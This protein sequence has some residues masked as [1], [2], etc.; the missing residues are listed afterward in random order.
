M[1]NYLLQAVADQTTLPGAQQGEHFFV[2][3]NIEGQLFRQSFIFLVQ[4]RLINGLKTKHFGCWI[5]TMMAGRTFTPPPENC[6]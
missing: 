2:T 3:F 6:A 4:K 1:W 5:S